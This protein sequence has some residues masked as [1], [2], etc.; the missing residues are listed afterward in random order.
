M[1]ITLHNNIYPSAQHVSNVD[2]SIERDILLVERRENK[3]TNSAEVKQSNVSN[4]TNQNNVNEMSENEISQNEIHDNT[5]EVNDMD[6]I[7]Q[8]ELVENNNTIEH[9]RT[10]VNRNETCRNYKEKNV[11]TFNSTYQLTFHTVQSSSI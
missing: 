9:S 4:N 6:G 2:D 11:P 5:S 10:T 1:I 8:S 3:T 7:E